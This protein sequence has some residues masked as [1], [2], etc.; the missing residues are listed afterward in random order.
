MLRTYNAYKAVLKRNHLEGIDNALNL[1]VS[2]AQRQLH[3]PQEVYVTFLE[4]K[5]ESNQKY[6]GEQIAKALEKL[7]EIKPFAKDN[8]IYLETQKNRTEGIY[9]S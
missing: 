9:C 5:P 2:E 6:R 7:A 1:G 8:S 3:R 4:K